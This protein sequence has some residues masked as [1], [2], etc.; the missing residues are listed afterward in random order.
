MHEL[1]ERLGKLLKERHL[2]IATAESCTAGG[3]AAAIASVNGA[4]AYLKGGVVCYATELKEKLLGVSVECIENFGVVSRETAIEMNRGVRKLTGAD[5]AISITGYAGETGGDQ[6]AENG[7][8][9]IC[10]GVNGK[11]QNSEGESYTEKMKVNAD[12]ATNLQ[13]AIN[14]ALQMTIDVMIASSQL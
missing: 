4:S 6:F 5:V 13:N 8:I 1:A 11:E 2:T 3:I 7:T 10:V 12:R 9:W 14:K